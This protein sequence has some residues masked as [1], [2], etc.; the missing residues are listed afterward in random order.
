MISIK[1]RILVIGSQFVN[2]ESQDLAGQSK[3]T[4]CNSI[5]LA[6]INKNDK[7][8]VVKISTVFAPVY[9]VAC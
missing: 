1:N 2:K 3:E 5:A 9:I 4:F 7:A 8:A 6:V